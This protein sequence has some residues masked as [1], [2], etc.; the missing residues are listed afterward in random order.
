M[1]EGYILNVG[2]G[3]MTAIKF[4]NGKKMIIDC[5][6]TEDSADN[7]IEFLEEKG[8]DEIDVFINTHRDSDH[9][10]GIKILDENI[11]IYEIWD[12]GFP[13]STDANEY[14]DYMA[15]RREKTNR[16][17][18]AKTIDD[19]KFCEDIVLRYL[20]SNNGE[21]NEINDT[22]LVIK[23]DYLG[24]S[25]LFAGDASFKPW[26]EKVIPYYS[27][28][29]L[30]SNILVASHHGSI[31][32]F[33]DPADDK[34]YYTEHIKK[35][36][37]VLTIISVGDN[38]WDLPDE[39]AIEIYEN[40]S[41]GTINGTKVLRTDEDGNIYFKLKGYGSWEWKKGVR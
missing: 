17:L 38:Q 16:I 26:K 23:I 25:I 30:K 32:F 5:N 41:S 24:S 39:K 29:K 1:V 31:T 34:N 14:K 28:S 13:G 22:S 27:E 8:F 7:I 20:N 3:N 9:L 6:I 2:C 36:N 40:Y 19:G 10:R 37:P 11:P 12:N 15:L 18:K 33:D 21:T 35:I 4:E